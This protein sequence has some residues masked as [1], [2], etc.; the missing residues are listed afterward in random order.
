MSAGMLEE[1]DRAAK[2]LNISRQAVIKTLIRQALDQ[3]YLARG[4]RLSVGRK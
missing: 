1:L 4:S 3:Q 2:E